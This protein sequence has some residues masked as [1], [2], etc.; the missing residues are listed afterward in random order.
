MKDSDPEACVFSKGGISIIAEYKGG[1]AWMVL[2]RMAGMDEASVQTLLK[3]E[4][5]DSGWSAPIKLVNQEV[6]CS[7]DHER[8]AILIQGKRLDDISSFKFVT[9]GFAK[10]NREDYET[11]LAKIPEEVQRRQSGKPLLGL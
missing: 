1:K 11:K 2:Y 6:R 10:A 9:K 8:L 3:V 4:A 7:A 5:A